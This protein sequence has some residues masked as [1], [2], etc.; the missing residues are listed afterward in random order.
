MIESMLSS[1]SDSSSSR[2]LGT[3]TLCHFRLVCLLTLSHV[4]VLQMIMLQ[5]GG[6]TSQVVVATMGLVAMTHSAQ[7]V[8]VQLV[9]HVQMTKMLGEMMMMMSDARDQIQLAAPLSLVCHCWT[10][11]VMDDKW[12]ERLIKAS[13]A[14]HVLSLYLETC[15]A[16]VVIF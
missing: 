9:L 14:F 1:Y 7:V 16:A 10:F 8:L 5:I 13:D 11:V 15:T 4:L 6:V 3:L 2:H 12:G